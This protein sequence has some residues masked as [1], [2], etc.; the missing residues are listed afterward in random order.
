MIRT[1]VSELESKLAERDESALG[2]TRE[3]VE[4]FIA[5]VNEVRENA[6][7]AINELKDQ[8]KDADY[9]TAHKLQALITQQLAI[10]EAAIESA[11]TQMESVIEQMQDA[12][13]SAFEMAKNALSTTLA[14]KRTAFHASLDR[15]EA[16]F[17]DALN[18]NMNAFNESIAA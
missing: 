10:F 16:S 6:W 7:Y 1:F 4:K 11:L 13:D 5:E 12:Q 15:D 14:N 8:L 18:H 17:N 3:E 9:D 2:T